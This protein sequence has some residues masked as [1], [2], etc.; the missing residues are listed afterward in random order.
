MSVK[1][2]QHYR[3][4]KRKTKNPAFGQDMSQYLGDYA[5]N[6]LVTTALRGWTLNEKMLLSALLPTIRDII[7]SAPKKTVEATAKRLFEL[8]SDALRA[9]EDILTPAEIAEESANI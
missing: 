9:N 5:G 2:K 1:R 3:D 8:E 4:D 6:L 7:R